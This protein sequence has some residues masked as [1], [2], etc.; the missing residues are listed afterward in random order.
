LR[1]AETELY[2][3]ILLFLFLSATSS[4]AAAD[5]RKICCSKSPAQKSVPEKK[6]PVEK[7]VEPDEY[8]FGDPEELETRIVFIK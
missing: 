3:K 5:N 8:H 1:Q 7:A 4:C 2:L 6:E